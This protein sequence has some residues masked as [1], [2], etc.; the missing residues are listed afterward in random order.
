MNVS[1]LINP[2]NANINM[3]NPELVEYIRSSFEAGHTHSTISRELA[4]AGWSPAEINA[5]FAEVEHAR[6]PPVPRKEASAPDYGMHAAGNPGSG[7]HAKFFQ[8]QEGESVIFETK[9]LRGLFWYMF[10]IS[11]FPLLFVSFFLVGPFMGFFLVFFIISG[12]A[13]ESLYF[14]AIPAIFFVILLVADYIITRRR[15]NMRYYWITSQRV[16]TKQGFIGY[17]INSIPLERIS[18][19]I[20]SRSF[21]ERIFRFGSLHIQSLSGQVSFGK[22]GAEGNLK[23]IPKP[24]ETQGMIFSLVKQRREQAHLTF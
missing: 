12:L 14:L 1:M 21:V 8:L 4:R 7:Y 2:S 24:E 11:L 9:P 19:V 17:S 22:W 10:L 3:A 16:I 6:I 15:Y 18:D 23:A 13:T 5:A 20:I